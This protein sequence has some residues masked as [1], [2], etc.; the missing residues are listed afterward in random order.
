[1]NNISFVG[2]DLDGTLIDS[3]L[4]I[5]DCLKETLPKYVNEDIDEIIDTVFPLTIDQF[6]E[7]LNFKSKDS[8]LN[9]VK[10]FSQSFDSKYYKEINLFD[11]S[12]EVLKKSI[13]IFG[14][15]NVFILT[16]RREK[17]T[18]M[19]CKYLGISD[20]LGEERIFCTKKNNEN[21]PKVETLKKLIAE[22]NFISKNGLY[23]G[24]SP[25]DIESSLENNIMPIYL[26]NQPKLHILDKYKLSEGKNFFRDLRELTSFLVGL[27]NNNY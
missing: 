17:S 11:H 1:M 21:N 24:D 10:V 19:V 27:K 4:A 3:H 26:S 5:H 23:V 13:D 15:D 8:Y 22:L 7:Y 16:N 14:L 2:F 25:S 18:Y 9:F 12:I 20:V 6:P